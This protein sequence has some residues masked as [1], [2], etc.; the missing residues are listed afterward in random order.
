MGGLYV[1]ERNARFQYARDFI[2]SGLPGLS[3][4]YPAQVFRDR[5]VVFH[6]PQ[7]LHPRLRALI[8]PSGAQN[9]QRKMLLGIL[10]AQGKTPRPGFE[11]DW[12]LLMLAGHGGVGHV[13][14]FPGD[15]AAR[16]WYAEDQPAP[17]LPVGERLGATVHD[18]MAWLDV[19]ARTLLR[20]LGPT[21]TVGGAIPKLLLAIPAGGWTGEVSVPNRRHDPARVD[22]VLKLEPTQAYPGLVE[23]EALA[24]DIHAE[25]GFDVPRYWLCR[26]GELPAIAIERFDR[27]ANDVPLPLE[28]WFSILASGARDINSHFDGSYERIARAIDTPRLTL[29]GDRRDAKRHLYQRLVM[30]LLTGNG[31]LHLGNLS[32]LGA[33]ENARFSPVYDPAPMRAYSLHNLLCPIPFGDYGEYDG[34]SEHIIG[35]AEA[36]RNFARHLGIRHSEARELAH[37]MLQATADYPARVHALSTLPVEHKTRLASIAVKLRTLLQ[38]YVDAS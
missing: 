22:V 6:Q 27:D 18:L 16:A 36:L 7:L 37:A 19:D 26:V 9:F 21:P 33:G 25:A 3:L 23:L 35:F 12:E 20:T 31:D 38:A 13:D 28:S 1:T 17:L 11:E 32:V 24:L 34:S 5:P 15:D 14:V 2:D 10:R 8:P 29:V 4:V 30:A